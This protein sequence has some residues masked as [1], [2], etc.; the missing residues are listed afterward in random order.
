MGACEMKGKM[1]WDGMAVPFVREAGRLI[2]TETTVCKHMQ[3]E[4][5]ES[6]RA[7]AEAAALKTKEAEQRRLQMMAEALEGEDA[8]SSYDPYGR[9]VYK[10]VDLSKGGG[11]VEATAEVDLGGVKDGPVAFKKRKAGG[12]GGAGGGNRRR[13]M[14]DEDDD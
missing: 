5:L 7:L 9:G 3:A 6:E 11:V 8:L 13:K 4:R 2:N 10:G 12:G 1:E 14:R